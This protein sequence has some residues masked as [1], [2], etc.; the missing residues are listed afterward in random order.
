[1]FPIT[2]QFPYPKTL[3]DNSNLAQE[4]PDVYNGANLSLSKCYY[5]IL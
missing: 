1:M 4:Y 2:N 5:S 3:A